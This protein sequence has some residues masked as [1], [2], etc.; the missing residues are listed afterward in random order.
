LARA[1]G[2]TEASARVAS[3]RRI[4]VVIQNG[5]KEEVRSAVTRTL[6]LRVY[7]NGRYGSH[8]TSDFDGDALAR[9]VE[10]SVAMTR[11]LAPNP[12]RALPDPKYYA[13]RPRLDL[14]LNDERFDAVTMTDRMSRATAVHDAAREAAGKNL[15]SAT[16]AATDQQ[17]LWILR[18]TNGFEDQEQ[19]TFFWTWAAVSLEHKSGKRPSD[20]CEAGVRRDPSSLPLVAVGQEAAQRALAGAGAEKIASVTLP[21]IIENRALRTLLGGM[22]RP[23]D[24]WCL[25]QKRSCLEGRL[26]QAL[27]AEGLSIIDDPLLVGGHGS[28]RFDSE[29]LTA[30]RRPIFDRG[31]LR[32]Y[33]ID[34]YYGRKLKMAPTSGGP[35]NLVFSPG[36]LA[37]DALCQQAAKAILITGFLGGNANSTTGDFSH[38]LNGFL[39]ENG[40]RQ[41]PIASMNISS[42]HLRFWKMIAAVGSDPYPHADYRTPSVLLGPML[43]AGK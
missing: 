15:L 26:G 34:S 18:S 7:L 35:S 32:N 4:N 8:T 37:L 36:E 43:I 25:D 38:G 19:T 42:N 6:T 39:I 31:V 10:R 9:F 13:E 24:G 40:K 2:A 23:L 11:H 17:D 16:G 28:G 41:R 14:G 22:L 21:V 29:G 1:K 20:W 12:L 3:S 33:F 30:R 5:A 27:L